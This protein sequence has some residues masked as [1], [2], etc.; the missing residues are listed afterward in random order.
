MPFYKSE[1]AIIR[2]RKKIEGCVDKI[3]KDFLLQN[4]V[5]IEELS[6]EISDE[7]A[8]TYRNYGFTV[9]VIINNSLMDKYKYGLIIY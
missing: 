7:L 6:K 4:K 8:S 5:T 9:E 3:D 2:H 1:L